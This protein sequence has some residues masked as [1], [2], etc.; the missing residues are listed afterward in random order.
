MQ[1]WKASAMYKLNLLSWF[2]THKATFSIENALNYAIE[3]D[4][5]ANQECS[6]AKS[7]LCF[8]AK[9]TKV[10]FFKSNAFQFNEKKLFRINR[11][12]I[13]S[14]NLTLNMYWRELKWKKNSLRSPNL[15]SLNAQ[16]EC[17]FRVEIFNVDPVTLNIET[18]CWLL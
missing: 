4:E 16:F 11:K 10:F 2:T 13:D 14:V 15:G 12:W 1:S 9:F 3:N 18:I 17:I 6:G 7:H 8:H 5:M